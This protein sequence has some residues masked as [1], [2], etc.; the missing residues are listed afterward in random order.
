MSNGKFV[1]IL[2]ANNQLSNAYNIIDCKGKY[3]IPGLVDGH[4]HL[5][6]DEDKVFRNAPLYL[7]KGITTVFNMRGDSVLYSWKDR[8]KNEGLIVPNI[9]TSGEFINEPFVNTPLEAKNQVLKEKALGVD[10]IKFHEYFSDEE[11]RYLT[12]EG[13]SVE[14]FDALVMAA[15]ENNMP[16]TG[17]GMFSPHFENILDQN[18]SLAHLSAYLEYH[19]IPDGTDAFQKFSKWTKWALLLI[20]IFSIILFFKSKRNRLLSSILF[21]SNIFLF[22][23]WFNTV[24][25][26]NSVLIYSMLLLTVVIVSVLLGFLFKNQDFNSKIKNVL[27]KTVLIVILSIFTYS[28]SYWIPLFFRNTNS[29][30]EK[31]ADKSSNISVFTTMLLEGPNWF[32]LDH[33]NELKYLNKPIADRW[34][35]MEPWT[36][37]FLSRWKESNLKITDWSLSEKTILQKLRGKANIIMGTDAMGFPLIIPGSSAHYELKLINKFGLT[38]FETLQTST[39][40]AA[41]F[42]NKENEFGT[43]EIGKRADMVLLDKNPLQNLDALDNIN[44]VLVNGNWLNDKKIQ[45]LLKEIESK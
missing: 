20:S 14:T 29:A 31:L 32:G 6:K 43:I 38:P 8:I 37:T 11:R 3:L 41:K 19:L 18:M 39:T 5:Y 15:K 42:L 33:S 12:T 24:W 2:D 27:S 9:Y 7:S 10:F 25:V 45:L 35:T 36:T 4:V 28:I 16:I 21:C 1:D 26:G 40:N 23:I 44:G 17:H 22:A 13:V 34:S 30:I